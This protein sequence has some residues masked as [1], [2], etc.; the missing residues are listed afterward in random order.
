MIKKV[1]EKLVDT[2]SLRMEIDGK[3]KRKLQGQ[4]QFRRVRWEGMGRGE[5]TPAEVLGNPV[6]VSVAERSWEGPEL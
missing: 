3:T 2:E 4:V 1:P 6:T 5:W